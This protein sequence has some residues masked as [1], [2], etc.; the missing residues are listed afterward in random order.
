[1]RL[2]WSWRRAGRIIWDANLGFGACAAQEFCLVDLLDTEGLRLLRLR[3][4][5][6][7]DDDRGGLC[8]HAV[9]HVPAGSFN[10]LLGFR[11]G[12]RRQCAG[13]HVGLAAERPATRGG[14][15]LLHRQAEL[16]ESLDQLAVPRL[17]EESRYGFR[18]GRSDAA[19]GAKLLAR[20]FGTMKALAQASVEEISAIRGIGPAIAEAVAGFFDGRSDA[21][22]GADLL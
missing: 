11:A 17:G 8:R 15:R 21:A 7:T 18:D 14:D 1:M 13:D 5:V 9:G 2:A 22:D 20:H 19:D 16:L 10:Q 6:G 12:Q 4:G 3:P